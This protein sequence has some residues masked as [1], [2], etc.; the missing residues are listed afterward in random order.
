MKIVSI[1]GTRPQL[2]KASILSNEISKYEVDH[3]IINSGQHYDSELS[4]VFLNNLFNAK[5][6]IINLNISSKSELDFFSLTLKTLEQHLLDLKPDV[7][8]CYG[9]TN[10]TVCAAIASSKLKIPLAHIEAGVRDFSWDRPEEQNRIIVDRL[11]NY[12]F[13]PTPNSFNNLQKESKLFPES[14]FYFVGDVMRDLFINTK[15]K[16]TKPMIDLPDEFSLVTIHRKE[17]VDNKDNLE[18]IVKAL[19]ILSEETNLV[20]PIHPRTKKMLNKFNLKIN[21][22]EIPP[23]GYF[24]FQWL[25]QHASHIITDSGGA[26]KEATFHGKKCVLIFSGM[27]GWVEL[28]EK[29]YIRVVNANSEEIINAVNEL[30]TS[31]KVDLDFINSIFGAGDACQKII[32][33]LLE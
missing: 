23:Q 11:S 32:K 16:F 19:N 17:N 27:T 14:K 4:D 7:V 31:E 15:N 29:G 9:D 30:E 28:Q 18:E 25:M 20:L 1:I 5:G 2:I 22:I 12:L 13:C 10:T 6:C 26:Q 3:T 33:A 21:C 24:E 8:I